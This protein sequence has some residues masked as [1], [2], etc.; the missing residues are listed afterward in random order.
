[1][2]NI[3]IIV[4]LSRDLMDWVSPRLCYTV[5]DTDRTVCLMVDIKSH[6]KDI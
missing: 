5:G 3:G 2:V 4:Q 1:M 6:P